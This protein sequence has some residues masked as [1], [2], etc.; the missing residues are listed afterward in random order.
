[1]FAALRML[2]VFV[3]LGFLAGVVGIP[4]SLV[5]GDVRLL[6]RVVMGIMRAGIRTAG[7]RVEAVGKER[8]PRGVQCIFLANHVSNLDPPILF[9]EI[10]P[11]TSVL[12]KQEL[13]RIPML[14][15]AMRMGRFVPVERN[16]SR[17]AAKRSIDAARNV[18]ESG[19]HLLVFAEGT[20]STDG[21]LQPF[22]KG[23]FF[24][25][26]QTG[27]PIVPV[28]ISGTQRMMRKGSLAV[29]PGTARVE[30]LEAIDP[31][32]FRTREALMAA[33]RDAIAAA[34]PEEMRPH[35]PQGQPTAPSP[36]KA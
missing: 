22:K 1:M 11:M 16:N 7:I 9:P 8:I 17:E 14:G 20:R 36:A 15:R 21:R 31:A 2:I 34:L 3:V 29:H 28:A 26:Q 27:A 25:A 35:A 18:L 32:T 12:L 30:F 23:P 24:L 6:Y 19:L 4:Y 10:P 5:I 33:V 13:M